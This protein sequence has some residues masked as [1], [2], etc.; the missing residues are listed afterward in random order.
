MDDMTENAHRYSIKSSV[1]GLSGRQLVK[2]DITR[3][4]SFPASA[5]KITSSKRE[6]GS[7][8]N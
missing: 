5:A 2:F 4:S 8:S 7:S 6:R 1:V 3:P